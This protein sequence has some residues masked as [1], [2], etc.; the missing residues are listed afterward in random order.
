MSDL[1]VKVTSH[2]VELIVARVCPRA[3][4]EQSVCCGGVALH[5]LDD[6]AEASSA[7][8]VESQAAGCSLNGIKIVGQGPVVHC[9]KRISARD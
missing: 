7:V 6:K 8:S 4:L 2:K 9:A 3:D 5:E 1:T